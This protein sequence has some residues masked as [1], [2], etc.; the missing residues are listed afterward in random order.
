MNNVYWPP[1]TKE[2]TITTKDGTRLFAPA[3]EISDSSGKV[4]VAARSKA[5][6]NM[7][8]LEFEQATNGSAVFARIKQMVAQK[9]KAT[10]GDPNQYTKLLVVLFVEPPSQRILADFE[11]LGGWTVE[12]YRW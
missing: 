9:D 1:P 8:G 4:T 5:M 2:D 10:G 11:R 12:R 6:V 3:V 7:A